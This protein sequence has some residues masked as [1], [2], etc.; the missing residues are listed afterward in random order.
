MRFTQ[1]PTK[2]SL[3]GSFWSFDTWCGKWLAPLW[4]YDF[5]LLDQVRR[6]NIYVVQKIR[7]IEVMWGKMG[8]FFSIHLMCFWNF[9]CNSQKSQWCVFQKFHSKRRLIIHSFLTKA[10]FK[11]IKSHVVVLGY[12]VNCCQLTFY[13]CHVRNKCHILLKIQEI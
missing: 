6:S 9:A 2:S 5:L 1:V 10:T 12:I 13:F 4:E 3:N 11:V 7:A 8:R